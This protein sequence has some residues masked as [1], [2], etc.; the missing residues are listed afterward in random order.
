MIRFRASAAHN[1]QGAPSMSATS[2]SPSTTVTVP[3]QSFDFDVARH[4]EL[5]QRTLTKRSFLLLSTASAANRPHVAGLVYQMVD[6]HLYMNSDENSIK[7]RNIRENDRVAVVVPCRKLPFFPPFTIQ[8]QGKATLLPA[9]DPEIVQ[10]VREKRLKR[11]TSHGELD[12]PGLVFIRITPGRTVATFGL[13][14]P[15][16]RFVRDPLGAGRS[17]PWRA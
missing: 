3:S 17:I 13:G 16:L 10:L 12:L 6:G 7:V 15:L 5:T 1:Q 2:T 9:D 4:R 8:L 14:V 11:I